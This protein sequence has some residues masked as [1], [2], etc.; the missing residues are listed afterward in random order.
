V[1]DK[2][3]K[4]KEKELFSARR[5]GLTQRLKVLRERSSVLELELQN[6]TD[7]FFRVCIFGSARI[8]P[9][10]HIYRTTFDLAEGLGERGIDVLTGGG[11][12]LM[13]AANR[14]VLAGKE[15]SGSKSKSFGI[16]IELNR[17][18]EPSEHLNIKHH[19]RRFSSRLDDFMRLSHAVVVVQGGIGTL[20]EL[21][22]S[23]QLLQV[24]HLPP[25]PVILMD[26]EFW[27]GLI[28]WMKDKQ[29][30]RGLVSP[31]DFDWVTL[32]DEPSEA[33]EILARTHDEFL[34]KP[35]A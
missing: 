9:D 10:D 18:E 6:Y 12:G 28:D 7:H 27:A 33:I 32:V 23:W 14:G 3:K 22:F 21:F 19:H 8:K 24:G 25:R 16:T 30:S 35:R 34:K 13:E 2:D 1:S 26:S 29:L 5:R 11:P 31:H 4:D 17:F 15:K 20:L